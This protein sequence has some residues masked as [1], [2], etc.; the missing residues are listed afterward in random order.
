MTAFSRRHFV[1][2]AAAGTSAFWLAGSPTN[3]AAPAS[4]P[5]GRPGPDAHEDPRDVPS[6]GAWTGWGL[7][8]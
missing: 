6:N 4:A 8:G 2:T 7:P 3:W 1:G 5:A